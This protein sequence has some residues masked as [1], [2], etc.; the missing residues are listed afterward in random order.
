MMVI[1]IGH[2]FN[3]YPNSKCHFPPFLTYPLWYSSIIF[4]YSESMSSPLPSYNESDH[5]QSK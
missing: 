1:C 4:L 5:L 3:H 2:L